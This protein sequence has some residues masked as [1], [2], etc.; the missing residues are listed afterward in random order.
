MTP[1]VQYACLHLRIADPEPAAGNRDLQRLLTLAR[2]FSPRVM[3][4]SD[5]DVLLDVSGLGRLIGEPSDIA[6]ELTRALHDGGVT[7]G[8]GLGATQTMARLRA[9][10]ADRTASIAGLPVTRLQPLETLPPGMNARDRARPYDIF[11]Q[12]GI[13]TLGELAALPPD[14]LASRLGRRG[15]ALR[16]LACGEDLRSFV[17]DADVPRFVERLELEWPIEALEPLSFVFARLLDALSAALAR[18]DR[19]AAA[20]RLDARLTDRSTHRRVLQLPVAMRDA[21]VLRTLLLLDLESNPPP[22]AIDVVAIEIDPAPARITQFSLLARALPSPE[23]LST[24]TARLSALVGESYVGS[25]VLLDSHRPD[26]FALVRYAPENASGGSGAGAED[27]NGAAGA[28]LRRYRPPVA[29]RVSVRQGR[30]VHVASSRRGIPSGAVDDAAGPW[31]SS[32]EWW[33]DSSWNRNEWDV[34][35]KTGTVCRVFQNRTT[36]SWFVEGLYD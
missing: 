18:A 21:R 23:T 29:I 13:A 33:T 22:A 1:H 34:A 5:R 24:L 14:A 3:R 25:P 26:A 15:T 4:V 32:G 35:L 11:E 17:P 12:W 7:G 31:R 9:A 6:R 27:A 10:C 20:I 36:G 30:P 16:R 2:D 19:G 8:V 28:V